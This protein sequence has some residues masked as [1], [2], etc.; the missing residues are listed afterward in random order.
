MTTDPAPALE[1][2][3]ACPPL[4][5]YARGL[6]GHALHSYTK[7]PCTRRRRYAYLLCSEAVVCNSLAFARGPTPVSCREVSA[8]KPFE[9]SL[10]KGHKTRA[11]TRSGA[12]CSL[13][14]L[15]SSMPWAF[16]RRRK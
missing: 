11:A 13:P 8:N 6:G 9:H 10:R 14:R 16:L 7:A 3:H 1:S 15:R 2:Q 5:M 12:L 4:R